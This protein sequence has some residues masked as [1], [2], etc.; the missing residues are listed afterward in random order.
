[1]YGKSCRIKHMYTLI[2]LHA[3]IIPHLVQP[4]VLIYPLFFYIYIRYKYLPVLRYSSQLAYSYTT[5][6][7]S[8]LIT[9]SSLNPV[10]GCLCGH[11][12]C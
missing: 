1:M 12:A 11:K 4:M 9:R 5:E 2:T 3:N 8:R 6:S 7:V 10:C